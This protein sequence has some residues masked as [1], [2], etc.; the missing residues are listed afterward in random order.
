[1]GAAPAATMTYAAPAA[2]MT[3]GAP[4]ITYGAPVTTYSAAPV[5]PVGAVTY[6]APTATYGA[7]M[8]YSAPA[9]PGQAVYSISPERFQMI[10]AGQPLTQEEIMAMTGAGA[11]AAP[12]L[13]TVTGRSTAF[14]PA[15]QTG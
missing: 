8:S 10:M 6:A 11:A 1:M 13:G 2:T 15:F 3:Y 14:Q 9:Q 5:E 4:A 12:M 7:P